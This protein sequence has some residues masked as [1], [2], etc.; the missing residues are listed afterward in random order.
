MAVSATYF[1][2]K[3]AED[4]PVT[5][6]FDGA[7]IAISGANV[8]KILWPVGGLHAIDPPSLGHV[9]RLTHDG[10]P[11]ARLILKDEAFIVSLIERAPHLK[12]GVSAGDVFKIFGWIVGG[13]AV[14]G[15]AAWALIYLM[16]DQLAHVMPNSWRIRTGNAIEKAMADGAKR[17]DSKDGEAAI[18]TLIANLAEGTPDL[19]S[20]S[21]HVY[22]IPVM[23]AFAVSGGNIIVTKKLLDETTVPEEFA[24]VLAHE[25]GH[26][27][28][29][30]PEA[31]MIRLSGMQVLASLVTGSNGGNTAAN[32]ALLA[33]LLQHSRTMEAQA[34]EYART[35]LAKASIDPQGLRSFF[36][37][38]LGIEK[39]H[40]VGT[41]PFAALGNILSD[42]PGTEDRIKLIEPLPAGQ[43]PKP[44]MS[45]EQWQALKK[46]CG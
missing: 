20:V 36:E 11:G 40:N 10:W 7:A 32:A 38:I 18:G 34:D 9:F 14:A 39:K 26:V 19:P 15:I 35:T 5:V 33:A 25:I 12:G 16:P 37:K 2:G 21:V 28:Y 13:L 29:R 43:T 4:N 22:D 31:Q 41:G 27:Y 46:I 30:H 42:H 23:N 6:V 45:P 3:S 44:A 1:D 8:G 24:G 17:C